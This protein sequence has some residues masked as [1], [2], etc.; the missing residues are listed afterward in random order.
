MNSSTENVVLLGSYG[1]IAAPLA[2]LL[3]ERGCRL[4]LAGRN[5][6]A[7]QSQAADLK[8]RS[9]VEPF[10][11]PFDALDEAGHAAFFGRCCE[12]F[13]GEVTGVVL[14]FG[15]L[16]DQR[17]AEQD[18]AKARALLDTN[19]TAAV[20]ILEIAARYFETA[21]RGYIA[22]VSSVAG[23]RGRQSNYLYSAA[24]AGLSAYL[25]GLRN[26]LFRSGV[27]VITVKP[28]MVD[29]PMT[30]GIVKPRS[31]L[32]ARPERVAADIDRAIRRRRNEIYTPWFWRCIML[33]IRNVPEAIFKRLKL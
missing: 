23:D 21:H 22:A 14:C 1:G 2:R 32:V 18:W 17:E 16:T 12:R 27:H 30:T 8:V 15:T 29:T 26:R 25:Q 33:A 13:G 9:G 4:L 24:K 5:I 10:V 6:V 28:G 11:E 20:S 7:L 19:F 3:A 31:P